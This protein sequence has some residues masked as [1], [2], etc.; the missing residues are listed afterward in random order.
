MTTPTERQQPKQ[1]P[2][3]DDTQARATF[4]LMRDEERPDGLATRRK[5]AAVELVGALDA[6][7]KGA[8]FEV[9]HPAS[10]R[11]FDG[12]QLSFNPSPKSSA[13]VWIRANANGVTVAYADGDKQGTSDAGVEQ[14]ALGY[15]H[16]L[17]K[18]VGTKLDGRASATT[19]AAHP[20]EDALTVVANAVRDACDLALKRKPAPQR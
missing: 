9:T 13:S 1:P 6:A 19:G 7:L 14:P 15:D 12:A 8:G 20:P 16:L 10:T 18:F 3:Y 11:E 4:A 17:E 2:K 5:G